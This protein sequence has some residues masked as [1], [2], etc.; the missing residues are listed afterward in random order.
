MFRANHTH[1]HL[2]AKIHQGCNQILLKL[3]KM[4]FFLEG[5]EVQN[6]LLPVGFKTRVDALP[7]LSLAFA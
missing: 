5:T 2:N 3:V 1:N 7:C 6:F 4:D